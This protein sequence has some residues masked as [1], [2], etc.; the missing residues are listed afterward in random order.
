MTQELEMCNKTGSIQIKHTQLG[1]AGLHKVPSLK[2]KTQAFPRTASTVWK[3]T[4]KHV[5][6]EEE[7]ETKLRQDL[8]GVWLLSQVGKGWAN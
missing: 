6:L 3:L 1:N 2:K 8:S 4:S 5:N 7:I